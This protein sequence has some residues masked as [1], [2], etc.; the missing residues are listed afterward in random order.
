MAANGAVEGV[1]ALAVEPNVKGVAAVGA[2]VVAPEPNENGVALAVVFALD[3][4]KENMAAWICQSSDM[5]LAD[6]WNS[7][8][9]ANEFVFLKKGMSHHTEQNVVVVVVSVLV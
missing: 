1:V 5:R 9:S 7:F 8:L 2:V 6:E 3:A 4:S